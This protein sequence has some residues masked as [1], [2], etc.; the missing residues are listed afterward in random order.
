MPSVTVILELLAV[1]TIST[2]RLKVVAQTVTEVPQKCC[3]TQQEFLQSDARSVKN[4]YVF[5]YVAEA[6]TDRN[7]RK[8]KVGC[9]V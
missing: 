4:S 6:T 5:V 9:K 8:L 2:R 7:E 1:Q 3:R